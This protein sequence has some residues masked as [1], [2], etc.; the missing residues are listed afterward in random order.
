MM[1]F[2]DLLVIIGS[3]H[4]LYWNLLIMVLRS[5]GVCLGLQIGASQQLKLYWKLFQLENPQKM[6]QLANINKSH[7]TNNA[8]R[9]LVLLIYVLIL[10]RSWSRPMLKF[11]YLAFKYNSFLNL[12]SYCFTKLV[13]FFI[14]LVCRPLQHLPPQIQ[15]SR[16]EDLQ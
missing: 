10:F 7:L 3:F 4:N 14:Q 12:I 6:I 5:F 2:L 8:G 13:Q 16:P 11:V 1:D 15:I 9:Y